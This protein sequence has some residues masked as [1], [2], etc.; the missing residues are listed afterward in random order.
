MIVFG[1]GDLDLYGNP[2]WLYP[3]FGIS[4]YG[5]VVDLDGLD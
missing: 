1:G 3:V 2:Y 4:V 5:V